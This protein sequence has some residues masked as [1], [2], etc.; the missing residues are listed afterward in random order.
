MLN[1]SKQSR[2][3]VETWPQFRQTRL[4]A[5]ILAEN[6]RLHHAWRNVRML[7]TAAEYLIAEAARVYTLVCGRTLDFLACACGV[8]LLF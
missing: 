5:L 2:N 7:S 6:A 3:V 1:K 8:V 4:L